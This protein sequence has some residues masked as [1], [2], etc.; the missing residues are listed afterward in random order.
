MSSD[1]Q[2][3][4]RD[5]RIAACECIQCGEKDARTSRGLRLC[6]SCDDL[7]GDRQA[8]AKGYERRGVR[9]RPRKT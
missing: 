7:R 3:K 5:A 1:R 8:A 9:G 6:A 4:W 2:Q